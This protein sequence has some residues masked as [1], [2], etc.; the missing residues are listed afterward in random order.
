MA[1]GNGSIRTDFGHGRATAAVHQPK[2]SVQR[3]IAG[4]QAKIAF[5]LS[6]NPRNDC[7]RSSGFRHT[8]I[9]T[10]RARV[11]ALP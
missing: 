7:L 5:E 10:V 2:Q 11:H 8:A 9:H 1:F 4:G 3:T 6:P